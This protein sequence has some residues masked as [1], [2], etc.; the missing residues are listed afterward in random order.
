MC[1]YI[2]THT[3]LLLYP[4]EP[5][6]AVSHRFRLRRLAGLHEYKAGELDPPADMSDM[7]FPSL[8][9]STCLI[10]NAVEY[11]GPRMHL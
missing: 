10:R 9:Q 11:T 4:I 2:Y 5:I 6:W 1:N 3:K 7:L 8:E